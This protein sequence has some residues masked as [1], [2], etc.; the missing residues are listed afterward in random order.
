MNIEYGW[1]NSHMVYLYS[2]GISGSQIL[3]YTKKKNK[4]YVIE[5]KVSK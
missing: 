5:P 4:L 2:M 1:V 3:I